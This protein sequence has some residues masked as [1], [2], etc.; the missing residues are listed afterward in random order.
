MEAAIMHNIYSLFSN[1]D[2]ATLEQ[3]IVEDKSHGRMPLFVLGAA[4]GWCEVEVMDPGIT[5]MDNS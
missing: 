4:G 3:L 1:Q 2:T 5:R